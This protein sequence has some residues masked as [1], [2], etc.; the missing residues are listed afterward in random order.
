MPEL[1]PAPERRPR[2]VRTDALLSSACLAC[3]KPLKKR[4]RVA[5]SARCRAAHWRAAKGWRARQAK[6]RELR[7]LL[8]AALQR[9][10]DPA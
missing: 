1:T 4:Q 6:D 5:C 10:L 9:L 8:E 2:G 3:G 7:A